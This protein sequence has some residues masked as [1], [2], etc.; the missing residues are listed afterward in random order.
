MNIIVTST[1][2]YGLIGVRNYYLNSYYKCAFIILGS[3]LSSC[4]YHMTESIKH[5]MPGMGVS[6]VIQKH[7]LDVD[8]LFALLGVLVSLY[9]IKLQNIKPLIPYLF[10]GVI[11]TIIP[12][13][14]SGFF[15]SGTHM[16]IIPPIIKQ[17]LNPTEYRVNRGLEQIIYIIGHSIWHICMFH[18]SN[19]ISYN[20]KY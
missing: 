12:E 8:R 18:I 16:S 3:V 17:I 6:I 7:L 11:G 9:N 15:S 1:N 10:I 19:G 14:I 5:T 13:I 2:L 20:I 4:M